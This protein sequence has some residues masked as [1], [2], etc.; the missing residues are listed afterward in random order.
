MGKKY[1]LGQKRYISKYNYISKYKK[2]KLAKANVPK[3]SLFIL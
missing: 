1:I 2:D 3:V